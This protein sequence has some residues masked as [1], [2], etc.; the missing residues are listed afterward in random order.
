MEVRIKSNAKAVAKRV[1]KKGKA[2]SDSIKMALLKTGLVGLN[3]I[4]D[5]TA[6]G[7]AI[8][9]MFFKGYSEKYAFVRAKFGRTPVKV[10]LRFEGHMLDAMS[11]RANSR[12]AEIYFIRAEEAKKAAMVNKT[13]PFFGFSRLEEKELGQVFF[14]ALK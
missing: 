2:L 1:G 7:Q 14:R 11:V 8:G 5:R 13:R 9:G 10:D 12:Y 4:E 6:K 3:I